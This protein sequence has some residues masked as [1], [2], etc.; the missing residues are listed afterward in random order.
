MKLGKSL[1]WKMVAG[2]TAII[3]LLLVVIGTFVIRQV[4]QIEYRN[5]VKANQTLAQA[6]SDRFNENSDAFVHQIDFVT[7][8]GEISDIM[9]KGGISQA[10]IYSNRKELRSVITLRSI[11]MDAISGVY[12]YDIKGTLVTKW[13]KT[14]KREGAYRL[15]NTTDISRFTPD[16][17]VT[18]EFL[19]GHLVY[20][21]AVRTL[22]TRK[23]V[24]YI[25]FLYDDRVLKERLDVI[26]GN[27]NNFLGLYDSVDDV[28][29]CCDNI[30]KEAYLQA[31]ADQDLSDAQ[32]GITITVDGIGQMLLCSNEVMNDGW[33]FLSAVSNDDIY[34]M[35]SLLMLMILSFAL[36]AVLLILC[37]T[38]LNHTIITGPIAHIMDAVKKIQNEDYDITLDVH[39]G[40]EIEILADNLNIMARRIDELVNQNLK[41]NLA[42]KEMQITQL[43]HQIKP[44]FLYNTLECINALSQ[45]GRTE[46]VRI[47]T[48]AFAKLMKNRISDATFTTVE[49]ERACVDAFLQIYQTMQVGQLYY[50]II[51][52]PQCEGLRIPSMIIQPLVENA[53]LHGI[54]PSARQ[55]TCTVEIYREDDHLCIQVSDDGV[56]LS[57]EILESVNRY[58]AGKAN[59]ED[60]KKL[61]IGTRNV[62]DRIRYVYGASGSISVLS[63]AEWGTSITLML[64]IEV[65]Q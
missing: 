17:R 43:Q 57:R 22:E 50:S 47:I 37:I 49:E 33:Y 29:I 15:P 26:A 20:N 12:L 61:G 6:M 1:R 39:T 54:V 64:P 16:G 46:E 13:E 52:D 55:G 7:L 40:D 48:G 42:Y 63:D 11:A 21:R 24:G 45:M 27:S 31:L 8:D 58:I 18:S 60:K 4:S 25:T 59:E 2:S 32:G 36:I 23:I 9:E 5:A 14:P 41:A 65:N 34:E 62:V 10:E 30:D 35:Q 56:G 3:T 44:H 53:V 51:V 28:L 19:D 38:A